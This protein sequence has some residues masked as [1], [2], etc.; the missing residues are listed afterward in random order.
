MESDALHVVERWRRVDLDTLEYR[1]T[2]E[3]PKVLSPG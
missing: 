1:A 2:V 3:D